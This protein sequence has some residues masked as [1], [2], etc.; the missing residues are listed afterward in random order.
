MRPR[1]PVVADGLTTPKRRN[2]C[3]PSAHQYRGGD[4]RLV[5]AY[6]FD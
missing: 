3:I 2:P 1:Y 4:Y 5:A 6:P